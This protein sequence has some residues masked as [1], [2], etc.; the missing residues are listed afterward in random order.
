MIFVSSLTSRVSRLMIFVS[1]LTSRVSWLLIFVSSL[2]SRVSWLLIFVSSLT[3]MLPLSRGLRGKGVTG[4]Y[5]ALP[6]RMRCSLR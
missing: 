1:S 6:L 2:T 3:A 4:V 5:T